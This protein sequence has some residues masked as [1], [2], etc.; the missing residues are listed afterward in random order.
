MKLIINFEVSEL[1]GKCEEYFFSLEILMKEKGRKRRG[2]GANW[3]FECN[4]YLKWIFFWMTMI[5]GE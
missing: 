5:P 1:F 2:I 4:T 3:F